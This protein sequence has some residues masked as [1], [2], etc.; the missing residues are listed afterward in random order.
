MYKAK[1][2]FFPKRKFAVYYNLRLKEIK[3]LLRFGVNVWTFFK[4]Y[5]LPCHMKASVNDIGSFVSYDMLFAFSLIFSQNNKKESNQTNPVYSK[6]PKN[7]LHLYGNFFGPNIKMQKLWFQIFQFSIV[8]YLCTLHN[9][10]NLN[11]TMSV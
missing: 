9:Y 6:I 8:F 11:S 1:Q 3:N 5:S 4:A 7:N 2:I 10:T